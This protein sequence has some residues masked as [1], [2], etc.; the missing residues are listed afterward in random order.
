M[1][2]GVKYTWSKLGLCTHWLHGLPGMQ[3]SFCKYCLLPRGVVRMKGSN[4]LKYL[5]QGMC[6]TILAM[7]IISDA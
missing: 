4:T 2:F 5:A 3:C 6:S 7:I 1:G